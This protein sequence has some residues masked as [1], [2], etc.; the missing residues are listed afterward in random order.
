M[1]EK[2]AEPHYDTAETIVSEKDSEN[3]L[4][5]NYPNVDEKKLLRKMDFII[6]PMLGFCQVFNFLDRINICKLIVHVLLMQCTHAF[7]S[8]IDFLCINLLYHHSQCKNRWLDQRP[9]T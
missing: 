2:V 5:A 9:C 3:A 8:S 6:L 7:V 1:A 4:Y